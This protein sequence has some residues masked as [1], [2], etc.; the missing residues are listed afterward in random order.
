MRRT[1]RN[2]EVR[3]SNREADNSS[4]IEKERKK[5]THRQKY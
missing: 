5:D 4:E 1:D 2:T 3:M